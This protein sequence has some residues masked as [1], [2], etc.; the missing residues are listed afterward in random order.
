[1]YVEFLFHAIMLGYV[2]RENNLI[3]P[4]DLSQVPYMLTASK[5][6]ICSYAMVLYNS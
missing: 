3:K 6:E 1:M 4:K 2:G 5:S